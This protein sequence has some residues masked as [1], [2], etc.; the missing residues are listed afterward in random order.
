VSLFDPTEFA[1]IDTPVEVLSA[2]Q[3]RTQRARVA[4]ANGRHPANGL[5]IDTT[6]HCGDCVHLICALHDGHPRHY[7]KCPYH[8]LG[9]T[10]S[11][12]S[13]MRKS[14]PACPHFEEATA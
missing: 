11:A 2:D 13:D 10:F 8:R 7:F 9:H 12:A 3:R 6:H 1:V 14:W 5:P 4:I